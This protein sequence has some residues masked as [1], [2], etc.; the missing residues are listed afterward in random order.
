MGNGWRKRVGSKS[1]L[2]QIDNLWFIPL[3]IK[4]FAFIYV[5]LSTSFNERK[6]FPIFWKIRF[7]KDKNIRPC[8]WSII[9][10]IIVS[11]NLIKHKHWFNIIIG[12]DKHPENKI[13]YPHRTRQNYAAHLLVGESGLRA[14]STLS[15]A[16][17]MLHI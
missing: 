2:L 3:Y 15:L 6:K 12:S 8:S 13:C 16:S 5:I 7:K 1:Y 17:H 11:F 14:V 4:L 9:I 10:T